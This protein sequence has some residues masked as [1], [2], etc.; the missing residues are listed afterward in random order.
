[1][2]EKATLVTHANRETLAAKYNEEDGT[3]VPIAIGYYLV[4]GFGD[5]LGY[6]MLSAA[7]FAQKYE[8][9]PDIRNG[10]FEAVRK[11]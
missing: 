1:M 5:H 9:G 3:G 6:E 2:A 10:F 4:A 11:Q 7:S 8:R